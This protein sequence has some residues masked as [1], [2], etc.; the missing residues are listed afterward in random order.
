MYLYY[1]DWRSDGDQVAGA[2]VV[3]N[4]VAVAQVVDQVAGG[5][6]VVDQEAGAQVLDQV[7]GT[8]VVDHR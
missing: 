7:A 5:Q 3:V 8:H 6:V 4:K 1:F 2:Q